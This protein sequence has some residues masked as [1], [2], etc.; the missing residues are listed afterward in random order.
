MLSRNMGYSIISAV[1][2]HPHSCYVFTTF[3]GTCPDLPSFA[4]PV[5]VLTISVATTY[6][7]I[8]AKQ[9]NLSKLGGF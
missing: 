5:I 9:G 4:Y 8:A 6:L 7:A 2:T 3:D 1:V